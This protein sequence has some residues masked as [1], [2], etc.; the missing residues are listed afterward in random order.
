MLQTFLKDLSHNR[1]P[2]QLIIQLTDRCNAKCPQCGMRVTENFKRSTLDVDTVKRTLDAAAKKGI[3]AVSFTGGE[4]LLLLDPLVELIHYAGSLGFKHIRTGTNGFI[5]RESDRF[6]AKI[7]QIAERLARTPLRNFWISIDSSRPDLHE[8]MRGFTGIVRGIE[9][10]LPIFHAHGIYPSANLG[11][12]RNMGGMARRQRLQASANSRSYLEKF[13]AEYAAAFD[14]FYRFVINLGFTMASVCYP[15]SVEDETEDAHLKPV[16]AASAVDPVIR[17][18]RREKSILFQALMETVP[19]FR[20]QI[21]VF[22][23]LCSLYALRKQY[24]EP[25]HSGY[26]CRG[27]IDYFFIDASDGNTYPC[28]YRGQENLGKFWNLDRNTIDPHQNCFLCDWECFRDPSEIFGPLLQGARNL[29]GLCKKVFHDPAFF[30]YWIGDLAYYQMCD[31]F[32][33][34]SAPRFQHLKVVKPL[35]MPQV[36]EH[37]VTAC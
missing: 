18:S 26:P 25:A 31:L 21:R 29:K 28:G 14:E 17:F 5:F 15:M 34:R 10:A 11:I 33:G 8:E 37:L 13:K 2:G 23:P 19:R 7:N 30:R 36:K 6:R 24:A 12:N 3:Q 22:T 35:V 9:Q 27:G 16:Y 4:P 20:P 32:N 1:L